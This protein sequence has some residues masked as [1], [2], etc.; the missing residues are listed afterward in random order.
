MER[1]LPGTVLENKGRK[2]A[3]VSRRKPHASRD[4]EPF[5]SSSVQAANN[6][7]KAILGSWRGRETFWRVKMKTLLS[8]SIKTG[9]L[10]LGLAAAGLSA[11]VPAA[12]MPL[13]T[14]SVPTTATALEIVPAR[15]EWAGNNDRGGYWNRGDYWRYN[16]GFRSWH[17][18]RSHSWQGDRWLRDDWRRGYRD[19]WRW[20]HNYRRHYGGSGIY[21]GLGGF[22]IGPAFNDYYYAPRRTYRTYRGGSAHVQWC[23][24]RYRSYRAWDNTFQPYNGPRRQCFSPY[25]W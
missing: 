20:R 11:A 1:G 24:N 15:A 12:T 3:V 25:R 10:A 7:V 21:F 23:Y 6:I 19:N 5:C 4:L 2:T 13:T 14:P 18:D 17:G 22:G 9:L 16:R 8:H